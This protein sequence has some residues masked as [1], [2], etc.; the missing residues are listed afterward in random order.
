MKNFEYWVTKLTI[1][2]YKLKHNI[3]DE[4]WNARVKRQTEII[5]TERLTR[6]INF[7]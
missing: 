5:T 7:K 6:D 3:S 4:E 2:N 1:Y